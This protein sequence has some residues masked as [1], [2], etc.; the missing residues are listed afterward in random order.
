MMN[1][2]NTSPVAGAANKWRKCTWRWPPCDKWMQ[3]NKNKQ[4]ASHNTRFNNG[5]HPWDP[6]TVATAN[7]AAT[8]H[9]TTTTTTP[10]DTTTTANTKKKKKKP[11]NRPNPNNPNNGPRPQVEGNA[12]VAQ[13]KKTEGPR[14]SNN[15]KRR[16]RPNRKPGGEGPKNPDQN[17]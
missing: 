6:T 17:A 16:N 8:V 12:P 14:P 7:T 13:E 9:T 10:A 15:N 5:E 1:S 3:N 2:N 11:G 4:C